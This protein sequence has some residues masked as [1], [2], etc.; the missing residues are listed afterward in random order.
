MICILNA[1]CQRGTWLLD[2]KRGGEP[3][4]PWNL[5]FATDVSSLARHAEF[6][7]ST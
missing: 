3:L 2:K 6:L 7:G 1:R 4:T 5:T